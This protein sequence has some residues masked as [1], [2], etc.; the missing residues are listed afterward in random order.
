LE[1]YS[2][3]RE[4]AEKAL[5]LAPDMIEAKLRLAYI[6]IGNKISNHGINGP[7]K[8]TNEENEEYDKALH[9]LSK[10]IE[11]RLVVSGK[12]GICLGGDSARYE[13]V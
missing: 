8:R 12:C 1:R 9:E 3:S 6:P 13:I 7:A 11:E 2:E 5:E 4:P 10:I